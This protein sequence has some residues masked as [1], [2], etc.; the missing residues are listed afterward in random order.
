MYAAHLEFQ[1]T[2]IDLALV[3]KL[4]DELAAFHPA[5]GTSPHGLVDAQ[6]SV[7]GETFEQATTIALNAARATGLPIARVELI[8]E[9][10]FARRLE[11]PAMPDIIGA[12]EAA[13][14]LG[15]SRQA[16]GKMHETGRLRGQLV[17]KSLVFPAAEVRALVAQLDVDKPA[18]VSRP[19]AAP[20]RA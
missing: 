9:E 18:R 5:V 15:V 20:A 16:V 10:E 17:G 7:P 8:T 4:M 3:D 2:K 1:R 14:L 11:V 13:E 12:S 6:I 19:K